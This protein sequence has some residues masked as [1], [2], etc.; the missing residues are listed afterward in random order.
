ML[1]DIS[2]ILDFIVSLDNEMSFIAYDTLC[3]SMNF[4]LKHGRFQKGIPNIV[5]FFRF[6]YMQGNDA[7]TTVLL[8]CWKVVVLSNWLYGQD[9]FN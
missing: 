5:C 7:C 2:W 1:P 6:C 9:G 8:V 4:T 3:A